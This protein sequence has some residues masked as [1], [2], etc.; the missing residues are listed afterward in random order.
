MFKNIK[1]STGIYTIIGMF[2]LFLVLLMTMSFYM[3]QK[4]SNNFNDSFTN[5]ANIITLKQSMADLNRGLAQVNAIMLQSALNRELEEDDV[6]GAREYF[7]TA[8]NDINAFMNSPFLHDN[9]KAMAEGIR[10]VIYRILDASQTKL[11]YALNPSQSPDQMHSEIK[12]RQELYEKATAYSKLNDEMSKDF[13]QQAK[14]DYKNIVL[15]IIFASVVSLV[16]LVVTRIWLK[17]ALFVPLQKTS[18]WL[19]LIAGGTLTEKVHV[20]RKNEIGIMLNELE[21][22]REALTE[23]VSGIRN[24]VDRIHRSSGEIVSGNTDLSSRTEEQASALQQTAASMEELKIT[25]RQ[26]ADNAYTARQIAESASTSARHGGDVMVTLDDIMRQIMESSRQIADIN[27]V[28]DSIANQTNIL[29]L[30]AAVEAARA[31]EQGRGFAVVA[32]EVRNLAKR[33]ADAAKESRALITTCVANM[34]TGS[35]QVEKAGMAMKDI[36]KSVVQV[37]DIM[38]EITSASDEQSTGINQIA[39]A[40]NEMDLVTQ[41][42]ASMVEESAT[43]ANNMEEQV[44][45]LGELV[46]QFKVD[47]SELNNKSSDKIYKQTQLPT[48][49]PKSKKISHHDHAD[50][51]RWETF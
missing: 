13:V 37:T 17:Q 3:G 10:D 24:G 50:D 41:Q 5:S 22:M 51:D 36:V 4:G 18:G 40:V 39:Q 16:L 23:T 49:L 42:N 48:I 6:K 29:A 8:K 46:S 11:D 14:Q 31:G 44:E 35:Q 21:N 33:S 30:N 15:I 27:S 47:E 28:I 2:M 7:S 1:V 32:G 26:N 43:A 12:N 45:Q 19:Q 38:A 34:N 9:E 25:V 20:D